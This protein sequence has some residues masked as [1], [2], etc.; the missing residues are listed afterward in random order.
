MLLGTLLGTTSMLSFVSAPYI[1]GAAVDEGLR[2]HDRRALAGWAALLLGIAG[3]N[4]VLGLFRHRTMTKIRLDAGYRTIRLV[5]SRTVELGAALPRR[6]TAG[7]VV[8]IGVGD[9]WVIARG[10]TVTGPGVGAL[11]G[12]GVV[13]VLLVRIS[14]LLATV[15][16][17]GAPV[18]ALVVGPL[19]GS[20]QRAGDRYRGH[21]GELNGQ[22]VDVVG[23]LRL[24]NGLGGKDA[25]AARYRRGSAEVCASGNRLAGA[26]SWVH[27]SGTG[28][29]A[30]FLGVVTWLAAHQA[31]RGEITIGELT[32]VFGYAAALV[33]PVR[34]LIDTGNDASRALVAARRVTNLLAV[35]PEPLHGRDAP[36]GPAS[37]HDP[38]SGV[39]VEPGLITAVAGAGAA[40]VVDRLGRYGNTDAT[41][42]GD[43]LDEIAKA[44]IR[45]RIL[46][47][48]N[49]AHL[50]PGPLAE[51][52]AGRSVLDEDAVR[53]ALDVAVAHDVAAEVTAGGRNLSGGQRQRVRLARALYQDPEMLLAV[54]PTSAVDAHTEAAIAERLT[55][56][57]RGRAT[58]I[59]TTSPVLL[60]RADVVH[61]LHDGRVVASGTHRSLLTDEPGYRALVSRRT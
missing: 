58:L 31:V 1:I 22:L 52:V 11:I 13:A 46:V 8:T 12:Y 16:L 15:V 37:L 19:L 10:L 45:D 48:D 25:H 38:S 54:E 34:I 35:T 28:I 33:L 6:I 61:Y 40:A 24:L 51:V 27:A 18:I 7:E 49:E 14:P 5:L 17:A 57:R 2:A 50:F 21:A 59:A 44:A 36:T 4:A 29:P 42:N 9:V 26:A 30:L 23:G 60:D 55:S 20:M 47:A 41:W 53:H 32:A 3:V 56:A 43:R 39:T